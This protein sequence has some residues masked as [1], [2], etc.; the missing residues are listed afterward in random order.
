LHLS[1]I[2][3]NFLILFSGKLYSILLSFVF[4]VK[5]EFVETERVKL[6]FLVLILSKFFVIPENILLY[7]ELILEIFLVV[8]DILISNLSITFFPADK[9]LFFFPILSTD[10]NFFKLIFSF[11]FSFNLFLFSISNFFFFTFSNFG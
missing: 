6:L 10:E 11:S 7:P 1:N 2:V 5:I 9:N 8:L 4:L 3:L